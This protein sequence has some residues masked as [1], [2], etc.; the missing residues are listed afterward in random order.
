MTR[1][2]AVVSI[3]LFMTVTA[4]H[5]HKV[6][7]THKVTGTELKVEVFFEDDTPADGAKVQL[8]HGDEVVA[9]GRADETGVWKTVAPSPGEYE[10]RAEH[11]GHVAKEPL[12]VRGDSSAAA[13]PAPADRQD[14]VGMQ[15]GG[16]AAGVGVIAVVFGAITLARRRKTDGRDGPL[17]PTL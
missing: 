8:R 5:A 4:A 9:E 2:S 3:A 14:A 13:E 7:V 11:T 6:M 1:R 10:V 12:T 17:A 16:I 15:W